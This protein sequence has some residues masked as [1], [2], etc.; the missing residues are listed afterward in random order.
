M[1]NRRQ[2][3]ALGIATPG[4]IALTS[5]GPNASEGSGNGD[6]ESTLRFAWWGNSTRHEL[7]REAVEAYSEVDN[8]IDIS[9]EPN[10]WSGYW[11]KLATQ[12]AGGELPDVIQMDEKYMA[13]Y[14]SRETLLDLTEGG[15]DTSAF[16]EGTVEVGELSD[17]RL[18]GIN[19][20][21]NAFAVIANPS[22]FEA[23]GVEL[24]DD[25]T[26]TWD[27][28]IDIAVEITQASD[29]GTF[30]INQIG[31]NETT[32]HVYMRQLGLDRYENGGLAF[33]A[34][35]AAEYFE[36]MQTIQDSGAGPSATLA[37][38]DG[39]QS[40]DQSR[41]NTGRA[42]MT[43]A[44]SNQAV[45]HDDAVSEGIVILRPPSLTGSAA[46]VGLWYKASMYWSISATA[47]DPEAALAFVDYLANSPD[48]GSILSVERGVPPNLQ[49]R[50]AIM[51]ELDDANLQVVE[52][53]EAIEG[54]LGPAPE[55][56]PP[57]AGELMNIINRAGEDMLFGS[58]TAEEAGQRLVDELE[59][60]LS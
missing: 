13:E 34:E 6:A 7:T 29:D 46:D 18:T 21:V 24:P 28:L 49:V 4:A 16:G 9:V 45:A 30:G 50:D 11:D 5:C 37:V 32:F 23:A 10:E 25:T 35:A 15:F 53:I 56:T 44:L 51:P 12:A 59:A 26:W 47:Q 36:F 42:G 40:F 31:L 58:I 41:F 3:L 54:E 33:D 55:L 43:V 57:G 27:D 19:A 2:A 8:A 38:E 20:G 1:I 14:G 22:V 39:A 52:Y 17:G 48:A 60:A